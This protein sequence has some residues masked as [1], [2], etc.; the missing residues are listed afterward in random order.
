MYIHR[1]VYK[2]ICMYIKFHIYV[3]KYTFVPIWKKRRK[4]RRQ[5]QTLPVTDSPLATTSPVQRKCEEVLKRCETSKED[6]MRSR[7]CGSEFI[8]AKT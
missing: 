2:E 4:C 3:Q 1:R 8:F 6:L 5:K 7:R